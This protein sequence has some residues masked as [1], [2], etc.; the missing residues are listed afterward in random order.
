MPSRPYRG[1][2]NSDRGRA[3]SYEIPMED[4]LR[5]TAKERAWFDAQVRDRVIRFGE[6]RP[7]WAAFDEAR[8]PGCRRALFGYIGT[9]GSNS[10]RYRTAQIP[11]ENFG[12]NIVISEPGNGAPLHVH[13]TE[14]VFFALSGRWCVYWG[15]EGEERLFLE[16]WDAVSIPPQVFR[17]FWNASTE[18]AYLMTI[19][20][21]GDAP[22][23]AYAES[24]RRALATFDRR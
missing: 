11:A 18:P 24:V 9:G 10:E 6:I 2:R 8:M 22:P 3:L 1:S 15:L 13:T 21:G 4:N 19:Q 14:E 7:D 12:F 5:L 20:G 16:R 17:G 23:V